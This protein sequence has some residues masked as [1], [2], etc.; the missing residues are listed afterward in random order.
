[1]NEPREIKRLHEPN[2]QEE[3]GANLLCPADQCH[4]GEDDD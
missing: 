2:V 1:M 3:E 4:V